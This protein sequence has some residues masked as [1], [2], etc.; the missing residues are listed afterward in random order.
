[1]PK[2][3][4]SRQLERQK[5]SVADTPLGM[6]TKGPDS[7]GIDELQAKADAFVGQQA[8]ATPTATEEDPGEMSMGS[9]L[10]KA[11]EMSIKGKD[12]AAGA[13]IANAAT[14]DGAIEAASLPNGKDEFGI[15][16]DVMVGV[17]HFAQVV[18]SAR[19][20]FEK[21]DWK[22]GVAMFLDMANG[23]NALIQKLDTLGVSE[24]VFPIIGGAIGGARQL[25]NL[26]RVNESMST[27]ND[28][29]AKVKLS[30]E[31]QKTIEAFKKEQNVSMIKHGTQAIINFAS[32]AAP[33]MGPAGPVVFGVLK[34]VVPAVATIRDTWINHI[35]ATHL[36]AEKRLGLDGSGKGSTKEVADLGN[37][38][39]Q[40][41]KVNG[42]I[43]AE[44]VVEEN[45]TGS[46]FSIEKMVAVYNELQFAKK[47]LN[48]LPAEDQ[49]RDAA[50][51]KVSGMENALST[52]I[53]EYN[54]EMARL[55][56]SYFNADFKPVNMESIQKLHD[57]HVECMHNVLLEAAERQRSIDESWFVAITSKTQDK[58]KILKEIYGGKVP[59][60][61][62]IRLSKL[63]AEADAKFWEKTRTAIG[64]AMKTVQM[65]K[66][67][68]V[69]K[70]ND[71]M[72]RNK[73]G[74][75]KQMQKADG[76]GLFQDPASFD[77]DVK[78]VVN[79][80]SL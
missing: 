59:D 49:G 55:T 36:K 79:T 31:D 30:A 63:T 73:E 21:K 10:G 64:N 38:L 39:M 48:A 65:S 56:G 57:Y 58:Q 33:F 8:T 34:A 22:S 60:K 19:D 61:V 71:I 17:Q 52:A 53:T 3:T 62:D 37:L 2:E 1:M 14:S 13:G 35:E 74:I 15:T 77:S 51:E 76:K 12:V 11:G 27:L 75:L 70:M 67:T 25:L 32:I 47:E 16:N 40:E 80:L 45:I 4:S 6:E 23:L 72:K 9:L 78:Q 69:K 50:Q 42:I 20:Y 7:A 26:S 5:V 46:S 66:A 43:D 28:M 18:Y 24:E 41:N 54:T 29:M 44:L 68:M